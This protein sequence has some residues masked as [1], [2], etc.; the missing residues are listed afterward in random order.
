MREITTFDTAWEHAERT[1]FEA[2]AGR[3]GDAPGKVAFM[4]VR[5]VQGMNWWLMEPQ[6]TSDLE[7]QLIRFKNPCTLRIPYLLRAVYAGRGDCQ[8]WAMNIVARTPIRKIEDS[9]LI[10]FRVSGFGRLEFVT[11]Q[12][13]N[14]RELRGAWQMEIGAWLTFST[15]GKP[16][17]S[18]GD[19]ETMEP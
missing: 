4:G 14:E 19:V 10:D 2:L 1:A 12:L 13:T 18:L 7:D 16:S 6:T 17:V 15:G 11:Q 9:N 5:G 3:M 8:K